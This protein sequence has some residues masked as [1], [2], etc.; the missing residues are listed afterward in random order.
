MRK[1]WFYTHLHVRSFLALIVCL[2]FSGSLSAQN[3]PPHYFHVPATAAPTVNYFAQ[4]QKTLSIYTQSEIASMV[5]PVNG[6]LIIDTIWFRH[7]GTATASAVNLTNLVITL[8]HTS[9]SLAVDTFA[10]NFNVGAPQV[11]LNA[12]SYTYTPNTGA[13]NIP[14]NNWTPIPLQVPFSYNFSDNLAVQIS[15]SGYSGTVMSNYAFLTLATVTQFS[16]IDTDTVAT[17]CVARPMIGFSAGCGPSFNL[18]PDTSLCQGQ[19]LIL[20][21]G[22]NSGSYL[23]STGDTT[24]TITATTSGVYS[25]Q[26]VNGSCIKN[27]SVAVIFHPVPQPVLGNDTILCPGNTLVLNALN[28]GATYLWNTNST[29]Q[30]ITVSQ[31]GIYVVSMALHPACPVSDTIQV[32][33]AEKPEL[34]GTRSLCGREGGIMLNAQNPG[35]SYLWSTGDTSQTLEIT[36]PGYYAITVSTGACVLYDTVEVTGDIYNGI[37]YVPNTITP[38]NDG[39]NDVFQVKGEGL[40]EFHIRIFNRWG[41]LIFESYDAAFVWD[42]RYKQ[43]IVQ[44]DTY[45][46][47]IDYKADCSNSGEVRKTG[48]INVLR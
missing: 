17:G 22:N 1:K 26:I 11:V 32:Y 48:H 19:N 45:V 5:S 43:Q 12:A 16:T 40:T 35:A 42:A 41:E 23:W 36:V 6:S 38:N 14:A 39:L 29:Q 21:P 20:S 24:Q 4:F 47:L 7:G 33:E 3:T 13:Q 27:D 10:S 15:F 9:L 18:G 37:V 31:A 30:S 44:E 34:G 28:Q 46:Y 25:L 2:F 8:G